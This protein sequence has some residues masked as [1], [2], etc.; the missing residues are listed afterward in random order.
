MPR[1]ELVLWA[2]PR[3]QTDALHEVILSTQC[4]T[5]SDVDRIKA[6]ATADGFHSFRVQVI[7]GTVP[8]FARCIAGARK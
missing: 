1:N 4:R 2:L 7:D 5:D 6:L 3:G 8:D